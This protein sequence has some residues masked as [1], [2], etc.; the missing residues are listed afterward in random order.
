MDIGS[1]FNLYT[2]GLRKFSEWLKGKKMR[3]LKEIQQ[4]N[5]SYTKHLVDVELEDIEHFLELYRDSP[6]NKENIKFVRM[7][8]EFLNSPENRKYSASYMSAM[9]S[10]LLAYFRINLAPIEIPFDSKSMHQV[11]L[12]EQLHGSELTVDDMFKILTDGKPSLLQK[13]VV[14]CKWHRG[15][16][17]STFAD[18]FNYVVW[19]QLVKYFGSTEFD[20]WD[21][22]KCPAPIWLTRVKTGYYHPGFLDYD[23]V[24][25][26]QDYLRFL[27]KK[28]R[29]MK[30][31]EP[32]FVTARNTPINTKWVSRVIP[33]LADKAG[34]QKIVDSYNSGY[35]R[36]TKTG[37][38]VR[39]LLESVILDHE[40]P[41]WFADMCIGHK[42]ADT[43]EK[44][45]QLFPEKQRIRYSKISKYVNIFTK[46]TMSLK[47]NSDPQI[48]QYEID[49]LKSKLEQKTVRQKETD[50][51][52]ED[53][54]EW[55]KSIDAHMQREN[56]KKHGTTEPEL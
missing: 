40:L 54:K 21:L 29:I 49:D 39:D 7:C 26:I 22:A 42:V 45:A 37:H 41:G 18:R 17:D 11:I 30:P 9:H 28:N 16:D 35:R 51:E 31:G 19:D 14:M 55:R 13:T 20:S 12:Q 27:K 50:K 6:S 44:Q 52:L 2:L 38:E 4:E 53:L 8:L 46:A 43:Y 34:V 3:L 24:K 33:E 48:M 15:L 56:M 1:T 25:L 32:L 47:A 36:R 23:A 10:G 5:D